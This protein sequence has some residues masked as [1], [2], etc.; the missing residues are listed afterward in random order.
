MTNKKGFSF[1]EILIVVFIFSLIAGGVFQIFTVGNTVYSTELALLDLQG[2]T[3]N[4][5]D[6]M[7]R[8]I[9]AS[10]SVT[11]TV[12]NANSDRITFT[13]PAATGIQY[14]L[15]G[16][17]LIREYPSGTTRII[18]SNMARMK[19]TLTG[20][21]LKIDVRADQTVSGRSFSFPLIEKVRLRNG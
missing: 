6:R 5:M 13:T 12:V 21:V 9:R 17:R 2:H 19:F 7:V 1:I 10:S 20:S 3:R 11:V 15:S 8:E 4:G 16:T 18:A 14:Y